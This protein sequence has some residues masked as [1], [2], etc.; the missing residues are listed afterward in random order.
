MVRQSV[1]S[2][3]LVKSLRE[4][5]DARH[6]LFRCII[7]TI[8][9]SRLAVARVVRADKW[10]EPVERDRSGQFCDRQVG[11]QGAVRGW[12]R[13][14]RHG[15]RLVGPSD[16]EMLAG[17]EELRAVV[18]RAS[19]P[20]DRLVAAPTHFDAFSFGASRI[21]RAYIGGTA[22]LHT[23][24]LARA[25]LI[26]TPSGVHGAGVSDPVP[27]RVTVG[28]P[29]RRRGGCAPIRPMRPARR[30]IRSC[31]RFS[32]RPQGSTKW[33]TRCGAWSSTTSWF[34]RLAGEPAGMW[35]TTWR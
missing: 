30:I 8:S 11:G 21:D 4:I 18:E 33:W 23:K 15:G 14:W 31:W 22:W 2:C 35:R 20:D 13:G 16:H 24:V 25:Q 5:Q 26:G 10:G 27:L 7:G 12:P 9:P 29:Q 19:A 3:R 17:R 28:R 1:L 6:F 32:R 34:E